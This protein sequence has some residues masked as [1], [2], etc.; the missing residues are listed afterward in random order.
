M[1][2]LAFDH[3]SIPIANVDGMLEFYRNLGFSVHEDRSPMFFSV[4]FGDQKIHFHGP[5]AWQADW[6]TL[7]AHTARPGCADLCFVWG[8]TL[9]SLRQQIDQA[10]VP[11][12]EGPATRLGGR[13]MG[14]VEGT[15][16]YIRDPDDNLL[17]F[18]VYGAPG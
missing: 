18:I 1:S 5:E 16:V 9:E 17:E 11:I 8:D 12:E 6:F 15:S 2:V 3:V 13:A 4:R 7:R 14:S 10:D